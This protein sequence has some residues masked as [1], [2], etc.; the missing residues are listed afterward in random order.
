MRCVYQR[1]T[2]GLCQ[3]RAML[4][5]LAIG[6]DETRV[7]LQVFHRDGRGRATLLLH[8]NPSTHAQFGALLPLLGDGP[9]LAYDH[10]GFGG[11]DDFVDGRHSLERSAE[12]VRGVLDAMGLDTPVDLV[13]HSHGAMVALAFA[14]SMPERCARL[15]LLGSGG[16]PAHGSYRLLRAPGVERLLRLSARLDFRTAVGGRFARAVIEAG[17]RQAARPDAI[18]AKLLEDEAELFER[19]PSSLVTMARLAGDNPCEKCARLAP[20]VRS[21]TWFVHGR[22]DAMVPS[23]YPRQLQALVPGSRFVEVEGGHLVHVLHPE[24]LRPVID[25]WRAISIGSAQPGR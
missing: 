9:L 17:T 12:V 24:R 3:A 10:P 8:G 7:D 22:G 11:S 13:G 1:T 2:S 25:A 20:S 5:R 21:P 4:R 15:L 16:T 18:S 14:A 6:A 19:R 23:M